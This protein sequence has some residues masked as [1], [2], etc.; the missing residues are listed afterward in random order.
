MSPKITGALALWFLSGCSPVGS[1]NADGATTSPP[2]VR[3]AEVEPLPTHREVGLYGITR[4]RERARIGFTSPGRLAGRPVDVGDVVAAGDVLAT[5]DLAGLRHAR[6][7]A[8]G[9]VTDLEARRA[10]LERD[11]ERLEA[12]GASQSVSPAEIERIRAEETSVRANLDAA[13]ASAAEAARQ[14]SEGVLRAPFAGVVAAVHAEPGEIVAP[15]APVVELAG[16]GSEVGLQVPERIWAVLRPGDPARVTLPALQRT[17][18][19]RVEIVSGATAPGGLFPVVVGLDE[20]F[21]AGLT[22]EVALR[23]PN[24]PGLSVP[25]R[26]LIDPVGSGPVVYRVAEDVVARVP[27][28]LGPLLGDRVAV[29]GALEPGDE[30]VVA[31]HAR[32]LDGDAVEVLR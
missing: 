29:V 27:V 1:A 7:A 14:L 24:G 23:V 30:I 13:R 4:A 32:L 17:V 10:Q 28:T 26:A 16:E 6:E 5:L 2:R 8:D 15:G 18:E 12:L 31:G 21:A 11:R 20:A 22:A 19:A 3:T 9:R 25:V